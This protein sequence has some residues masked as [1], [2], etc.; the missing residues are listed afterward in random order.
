MSLPMRGPAP[1]DD[2]AAKAWDDIM[3][4]AAAHALIVQAYGGVATLALPAEQ[5]KAGIRERV[6]RAERFELEER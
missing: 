6:L 3:R 4:L 2:E 5:R 1:S